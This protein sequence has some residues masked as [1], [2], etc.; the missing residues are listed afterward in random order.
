MGFKTLIKCKELRLMN[1]L[2]N[3]LSQSEIWY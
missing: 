1:T 2:K 3:I